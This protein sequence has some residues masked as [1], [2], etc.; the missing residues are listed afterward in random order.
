MGWGKH[1][2]WNLKGKGG[3][4]LMAASNGTEAVDLDQ[5]FSPPTR[6]EITAV[7]A[8]WM[9]RDINPYNAVVIKN[10]VLAGHYCELIRHDN[11]HYYFL[12][13][14]SDYTPGNQYPL[15]VWNHPG[16]DGVDVMVLNWFD[17]TFLT[18]E[19]MKR[20]Y[21][22][23]VPA[24]RGESIFIPTW[25]LYQSGGQPSKADWEVDDI[26][27][28]MN[29]T[30]ASYPVSKVYLYGQS[31]GGTVTLLTVIR[32]AL[33][34]N[35][36]ERLAEL[37]GGTNGFLDYIKQDCMAYLSSS[38]LPV[39]KVSCLVIQEALIPWTQQSIDLQEARHRILKR[40]PTL[41]AKWLPPVSLHHGGQDV[42]VNPQH[43]VSLDVK[44]AAYGTL[45]EYIPYPGGS[46][47][48]NTLAGCGAYVENW[49]TL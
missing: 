31:R 36:A 13:Y 34:G 38:T 49:L 14:P 19:Y 11:E 44:L 30:V 10:G 26:L 7:R 23:A 2:Q 18:T 3:N 4:N 39:D 16:Y 6:D 8:E 48:P 29:Y 1:N 21:F 42:L 35:D 43:S 5:L 37:F 45:H 20:N 24:Y 41:F 17:Y 25:G 33:K 32:W 9:S 12:R 47:D 46:H 22:Y 28:M 15:L 40:S 27:K